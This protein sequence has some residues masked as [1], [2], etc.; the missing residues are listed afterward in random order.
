MQNMVQ[1]L[2]RN[3]CSATKLHVGFWGNNSFG[4]LGVESPLGRAMRS[5]SLASIFAEDLD[6]VDVAADYTDLTELGG[7]ATY[8][9]TTSVGPPKTGHKKS[10][11]ALIR[12]NV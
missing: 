4:A 8:E 6:D 1:I 12:M 3:V 2:A 9:N 10:Q 11:K 7:H 5:P